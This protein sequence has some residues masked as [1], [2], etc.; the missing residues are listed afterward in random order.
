[1]IIIKM[2]ITLMPVVIA[3]ILNSIFCKSK[4]FLKLK[5]PIDMGKN[6]I[7]KKRI[8]GDHKTWK[9]FLG[10]I[11]FNILTTILW[12]LLC[13]ICE[14][15]EFDFLYIN[16]ENTILYNMFV[17]FLL[18]LAYALFEFPNSFL[19]R[20]IGIQPGKELKSNKKFI[21]AFFVILDQ[22]DSVFGTV[23]VVC[24]FY[25]LGVKNYFLYIVVGVIT[26]LVINMLL[27]LFKQRNNMF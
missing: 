18:G 20:R 23:L 2:Y 3:G 8:L 12:G 15:N 25:N 14:L 1:M 16:Y 19:K 27:Y 6:F 26:H 17:G 10:Y 11:F 4:L 13:N 24:L 5:K 21:K 9:G 22:A 7:D